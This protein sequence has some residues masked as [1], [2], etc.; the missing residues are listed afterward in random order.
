MTS[1][2]QPAALKRGKPRVQKEI[3]AALTQAIAVGRYPSD[4][5]L[6]RENDLCIEFGVS[7]TVIREVLKVLESKGIVRVRPRV[8]TTV[9]DREDW[10]VLDPDVI[11]WLGPDFFD[12]SMLASI[13]EARRTIEPAAAELAAMRATTQDVADMEEAWRQ[14]RDAK[15]FDAFNDADVIFHTTLLKASHNRVFAQLSGIIHAALS[16]ALGTSNRAA[17]DHGKA[18]QAHYALVDALR[19]RN[20]EEARR[21]AFGI[22]ELAAHDLAHAAEEEHASSREKADIAALAR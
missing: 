6:P 13:L 1:K 22:L 19:L 7:R 5:T 3:I 8:G 2:G 20:K 4:A 14:M 10:N 21:A 17:P 15:S 18:L 11:D 12:F 16:R 9:R